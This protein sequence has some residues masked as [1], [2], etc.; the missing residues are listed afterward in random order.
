MA[1]NVALRHFATTDGLF[2]GT[3]LVSKVTGLAAIALIQGFGPQAILFSSFLQMLATGVLEVP[4]GWVADR[5]GWA[6]TLR[7]ALQ[8]KVVITL[9][10]IAAVTCAAA[11][12][13]TAAWV[14]IALEAIVDAIASSLLNGSYQNAF[15]TW[16]RAR[17]G[18]QDGAP[19]LFLASYRFAQTIRLLLP[20]G[21]IGIVTLLRIIIPA[22]NVSTVVASA[23]LGLLIVL[24]LRGVVLARVSA[25]LAEQLGADRQR[26]FALTAVAAALRQHG[27]GDVQAVGTAMLGARRDFIAYLLSRLIAATAALFLMGYAMRQ[28]AALLGSE[29]AA[30]SVATAFAVGYYGLETLLSMTV[31][32]RLSAAN[33]PRILRWLGSIAVATVVAHGVFVQVAPSPWGAWVTLV[34]S[35]LACT[36]T[37]AA[38]QHQVSSRLDALIPKAIRATWLSVAESGALLL[39]AAVTGMALLF[40]PTIAYLVVLSLLAI[41]GGLL[42]LLAP[43]AR[44]PALIQRPFGQ[45]LRTHLLR[46]VLVCAVLFGISDLIASIRSI[47]QMQHNYESTLA[48]VM[49]SSIREPLTQGSFPEANLRLSRMEQAGTFLCYTLTAWDFSQDSCRTAHRTLLLVSP[50]V[51]PIRLGLR[52]T[53]PVGRLTVHFDRIPVLRAAFHRLA[54]DV[55]LVGL[56]GLI[57]FTVARRM[58]RRLACELED[59][60]RVAEH[61]DVPP[62]TVHGFTTAEFQRLAEQLVQWRQLLT[63][64]G[65]DIALGQIATQVAHDIRSPL[66]SIGTAARILGTEGVA[67]GR[68]AQAVN[69]LQLGCRRLEEIANDLLNKHTSG[70]PNAARDG[71]IAVVHAPF[72]LH[73]VCDALLGEFAAQALGEG[74]VFEKVYHAEAL[75]LR[76]DRTGWARALGNLIK[77]ALEAMQAQASERLRRLTLSTAVE[78]ES[79]VVRITD[80]GPGMP[81]TTSARILQG[82]HTEGKADGHGIGM[83]VVREMVAAHGGT[84]QVAS[85]VGV[86]TTFTLTVPAT[87]LEA[88]T[89][90]IPVVEGTLVTVIDDDA[91]MREQWRL[92]LWEHGVVCERFACWE[93]YVASP[94]AQDTANPSRTM[95]VDYH[96]ENSETDG[97]AIV[98]QLQARGVP[99]LLLCTAEYWKPSIREAAQTLGVR[100]CPKPVPRVVV[101][102]RANSAAPGIDDPPIPAAAEP[103]SATAT[104]LAA[105]SS[106]TAPVPGPHVLVIDDDADIQF[107][108]ELEQER[109]GVGK[110]TMFSS[111]E[112][113]EQTQPDYAQFDCAFVDKHIPNSVWRIDQVITHLKAAGVKRVIVAT[114]ESRIHTPDDPIWD[115]ADGVEQMKIPRTLP[116]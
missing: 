106:P 26:P 20:A 74:V 56:L 34:G 90:T 104:P 50:R 13:L 3:A 97:L 80:T 86:G 73:E 102:W 111:M 58:G 17:G 37:G 103:Q 65:K 8:C 94:A 18:A 79:I 101:E 5:F 105:T 114:G 107:A 49:L 2:R 52:D 96:F 55:L 24:A 70:T 22:Q 109:L 63:A 68:A 83:T 45:L 61:D 88:T 7:L 6:R 15:L 98:R 11:N 12:F 95:I 27:R 29:R 21:I 93:E 81:A 14:C 82:G 115:L 19:P 41:A 60:I 1:W 67:T 16:Y 32:P 59:V 33:G 38:V 57:A 44:A 31:F 84:V 4:T 76:G 23:L 46:A 87:R 72:A 78:N 116:V 43:D 69:L 30:W 91:G 99:H 77:N 54:L 89:I 40:A 51:F 100:L 25:D 10:M 35:I 42:S 64:R 28:C 92:V 39:Y 113:C 48:D 9:L 112:A 62:T 110:L 36:L 85:T 66:T 71:S 75:V 47:T 53:A 108:W